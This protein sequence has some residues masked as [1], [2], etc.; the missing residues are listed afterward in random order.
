MIRRSMKLLRPAGRLVFS[1]N[2]T[3][4]KLDADALQDLAIEDIS[5]ATVP[6][7]FERHARI[8]KCFVVRFK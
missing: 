3:R 8:H 2:Y 5:A 4:F 1:T 6:K 7:D